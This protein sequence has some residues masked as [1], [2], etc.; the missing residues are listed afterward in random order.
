M[1]VESVRFRNI[2]TK[3]SN[4]VLINI[5]NLAESINSVA[6][7][8]SYGASDSAPPDLSPSQMQPSE[9]QT[10]AAQPTIASP[11]GRSQLITTKE[12]GK[13][14]IMI[15]YNRSCQKQC[16]EIRKHLRVSG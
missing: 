11:A 10:V 16:E 6:K 3:F 13:P 9:P 2:E 1:K 7:C 4:T 15:S 14:H 8:L 12:L 5:E